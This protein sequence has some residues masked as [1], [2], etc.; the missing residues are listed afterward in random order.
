VFTV[1]VTVTAALT[2][3]SV[4]VARAECPN[5]Q[6][7]T[8]EVYAL[9]LP[10]CRA[11][12]QVS[13]V[14]KNLANAVGHAGLVQSSP[15][16]EAVTFFGLPFPGVAGAYGDVRYLSVRGSGEWLTEGL[17]PALGYEVSARTV[18]LSED[19]S[20]TVVNKIEGG[21]AYA[22]IRDN[23]TGVYELL[24]EAEVHFVDATADGSHII[25]ESEKQLLPEA[26]KGVAN[27]Y[28]WHDGELSLVGKLNTGIAP[29]GGAVAGPGGLAVGTSEGVG[30]LPGGATGK[31]YTQNTVSEDGSRVFF[32]EGVT[33]E[34][35]EEEV[36]FGE[37]SHGIIYMREPEAK[38]TVQVSAGAKPAYWRAAT[39]DGTFA[40][41]TEG[42]NLY[43][44]DVED[45]TRE[46]ITTGTPKVLGTLGAANNGSYIYFVAESVL[47]GTSGAIAGKGNLY[48]WRE[49]AGTRFIAALSTASEADKSDWTDYIYGDQIDEG[50]K[51]SRVAPT[52]ETALFA[53]TEQLTSYEN[54]PKSGSCNGAPGTGCAELYLYNPGTGVICVSCDPRPGIEVRTQAYLAENTVASFPTPENMFETRNLSANG[55]RVFFETDE[56]LVAQDTNGQ[57]NVYEWEREG[58]GSCERGSEAFDASN[59]GCIYLISTG[60]SGEPSYFGDASVDGSDVFFFTG[61]RL[62]GQDKDNNVDLY[63]ARVG[64]GIAAQNPLPAPAPCAEESCLRASASAP[65]FGAPS[66]TSLSGAGDLAPPAPGPSPTSTPRE[67]KAP[68]TRAQKLAKALKVCAKKSKRTRARC[69]EQAKKMYGAKRARKSAVGKRGGK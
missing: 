5:E 16:G 59:D 54:L 25:F 43:R 53:S 55:N 41:Y 51:S 68:L 42:E 45:T 12:E 69:E 20:L 38:R 63:D 26:A 47:P 50:F 61:Q 24:V 30:K 52:G 9:R 28:E 40:F 62:V 19:L 33:S 37:E 13:P 22:Y 44:Y 65:S 3:L 1:V 4:G 32:T 58:E 48:E 34:E 29:V 15:A 11:Y 56:P 17:T 57:M 60:Q 46:A 66:S 31:F 7:R 36:E 23:A 64:G 6:L 67:K 21:H 49:G 35:L 39:P 27:L 14:A 2:G 18:A 10:D 8:Q